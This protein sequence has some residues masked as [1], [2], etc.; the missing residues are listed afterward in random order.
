MPDRIIDYINNTHQQNQ[1]ESQRNQ[2]SQWL[3]MLSLIKFILLLWYFLTIAKILCLDKIHLRLHFYHFYGISLYHKGNRK[4][5]NLSQKSE[6]QNGQKIIM[7]Q[8]ITEIHQPSQN[9]ANQAD[10]TIHRIPFPYY[11][12]FCSVSSSS[13]GRTLLSYAYRSYMRLPRQWIRRPRPESHMWP[14]KG[15][16]MQRQYCWTGKRNR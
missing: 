1:L 11:V 12:S 8:V 9:I 3:I 16:Y 13:S 10:Y 7:Q 5:N 4:Q 14:R 2:I 15:Q 6:E